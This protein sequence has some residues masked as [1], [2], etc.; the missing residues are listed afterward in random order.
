M[1]VDALEI[2]QVVL[3]IAKMETDSVVQFDIKHIHWFV[4]I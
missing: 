3:T 2:S 1:I 4:V